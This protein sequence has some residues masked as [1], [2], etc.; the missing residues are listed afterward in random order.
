MKYIGLDISGNITAY[1]C[2][3]PVTGST[4]RPPPFVKGSGGL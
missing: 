1:A 2:L 3:L 4:M